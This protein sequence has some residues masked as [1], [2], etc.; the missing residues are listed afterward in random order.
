MKILKTLL[1]LWIWAIFWILGIKIYSWD[2]DIKQY[3]TNWKVDLV[4]IKNI[5]ADKST[6]ID[7]SKYHRFDEL[8]KIL[9]ADYFDQGKINSWKMLENAVK[10]YVD[11]IDDPYTVYLDSVQNSWF[12]QDLK[13]ETDFEW[14]WAVV[15][16]KDY[17]VLVEE[18]IKDSPAF[19]EWIL[20]LDR[21]VFVDTGSVKDLDINQ[22]VD[23][24]KW[25][26]WSKVKLL[27]ERY[28][29]SWSKELLEKNIT[30]DKL[31]VPSVTSKILN[32]AK[33]K[34]IWYINISVIGEETDNL[35]RKEIGN[36]KDQWIS[37][38][39]VDLRWNWWW[40]LPIAVDIA[41]HFIPEWKIV[42]SAKY[43]SLW[44]E[45]FKS[46]WFWQLENYP[47]V[48]LVDWI[49]ASAWEIIAM[50]LQEQIWAKLI[51]EKTFGK[52]SIQ[53]L[54]DFSDWTSIKY[55]IWKRYAPSGKNIDKEWVV[56]DL[57]VAF[58]M[59]WYLDNRIDSQLEKAQEVLNKMVR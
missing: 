7:E 29:K 9:E 15:S 28:K 53:T 8:Y 22:A 57:E 13:W 47:T 33:W 17:Y 39:I 12:E 48:V 36:L 31:N 44:D 51:W 19:K 58:D 54:E 45:T 10:A 43:R 56:P 35:M 6:Q 26:Q 38:I 11:W 5:F 21:I 30:R 49:T 52:W 1:I 18:V 4:W 14:I 32:W 40:F 27:I 42:V 37:G 25:P 16:K 55:T 34:K 46:K 24:I 20:A 2:L 23:K 41:S 3:L 50:A 59:T